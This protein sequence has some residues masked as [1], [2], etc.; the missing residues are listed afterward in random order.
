MTGTMNELYTTFREHAELRERVT[1]MEGQLGQI[2]QS[3]MRIES[4]VAARGPQH[5]DH[6]SLALQRAL[7]VFERSGKGSASPSLVLV[8]PAMIGAAATGALIMRFFMG[9]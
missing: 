9:G 6:G 7:D 8:I 3:L 2:A 4:A 5:A 1:A